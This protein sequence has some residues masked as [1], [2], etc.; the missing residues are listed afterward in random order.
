[1]RKVFHDQLEEIATRLAAMSRHATT[2]IRNASKALLT[3]DISLAEKTIS[4]DDEL[5]IMRDQLDDL[6]IHVLAQQQPVATDLRIVV[7]ALRMSA[8]IERMGDLACHVAQLVRMRYPHPV[9]E[10]PENETVTKML[11]LAERAGQ[12]ATKLIENH[13]LDLAQEIRE[14]DEKLDEL[15]EKMFTHAETQ[16]NPTK[17][18]DL[19]LLSRYLERYGDHAVSISKRVDF[20]VTGLHG[21]EVEL[22]LSE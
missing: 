11:E 18:V 17:T 9:V 19:T 20:L 1:M 12:A 16:T 8:T 22:K 10:E 6:A 15:H 3:Q 13:D 2:A 7:T 4:A 14:N 5:D 21:G